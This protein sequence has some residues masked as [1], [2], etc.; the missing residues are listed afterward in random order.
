MLLATGGLLLWLISWLSNFSFGGR[1]YKATF[2]FPNVGGMTVGTRVSYR[3]VRV[4]RVIGITPETGGVAVEAE[5]SP[6]DRLIPANSLIEAIQSGLVGETS[7]DITPLQALPSDGVK[8]P[9]LSANCD[10]EII[11]CNGSSLQGQ[12]SLNV[13]TLIRSLLRISNLVSDPDIVAGFRSFTQRAST[14]LGGLDRLSGEATGVL[15][16][17]RRAG[18]IGKVNAG[19]RSLTSLDSLNALP[20]VSGSIDRLTGDLSGVGGLT[21]DAR[22]LLQDLRG[23]GGL[24]NL[25][26]TLVEARKTLMLVGQTTEELRGFL[27]ANQNRIVGTL[28][29][30]R[31]TSDR[32]QTTLGALDPLLTGVQKSE[33]LGNLNTISANAAKLTKNLESLSAYLGDPA[34][35]VILQQLLESSRAAFSNIQKIT[36]D[37]DE[38]T[39]NPQLRQEL[40]RLIQGLSRLVSFSEQLQNEYAQGQTMAR[41]AVQIATIA[42]KSEKPGE[43]ETKSPPSSVQEKP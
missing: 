32:L 5:I 36:S 33:I 6:A 39:G 25:D 24:R 42:P 38:L 10:P 19:M 31:T 8:E 27:A 15:G 2:L 20:E 14:A 40:I 17:V 23:S 22:A 37:V 9:P 16:E 12:S 35:V 21:R 28:D 34:T 3:G 30:I 18:T 43:K 41:M 11:I 29:S 7:I 26:S 1:S 4:G 13:N